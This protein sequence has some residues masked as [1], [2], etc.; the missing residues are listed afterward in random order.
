VKTRALLFIA[1]ALLCA[2]CGGALHGSAQP[3]ASPAATAS[4][5]PPPP[6]PSQER[7]A[8]DEGAAIA[9]IRA[10]MET[11]V[12][13]AY[14][15]GERPAPRDAHAKAHGCVKAHF[16]VLAAVPQALRAG[17]FARPHVYTAW[18]RFSNA[19]G[20][21]DHFGLARGMA[22]KL[23]GVPGK[24]ILAAEAD[25]TTQDFLLVNYPVF[26]V[27]TDGEYVEFFK[28]SRDGKLPAFLATHPESAAITAAIS[29]QRVGDPLRV[30][31]FS[32]TPYALGTRYV[33]Y[34]ARPV[35]C[36]TGKALHDAAT[37]ALPKAADYLRTAMADSL[38]LGASC[39]SFMVQPQTDPAAMP[40][41]DATVLWDERASPF[42][43]VA[44]IVIP[45]QRF[46]SATQQ[47]F[48]ENL[49]Y[50][51]WHALPQHRPAG[52]INRIRR[53]VYDAISALRHD[54]N[55]V[56]RREPTGNERFPGSPTW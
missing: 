48:C 37:G 1:A 46:E 6:P 2:G 45:A 49:S 29:A 19:V 38:A 44:T 4:A 54:L 5:P 52:N 9:E 56:A 12:R 30:R 39:F 53:V 47:A 33:K 7:A 15:K 21:D 51:P 14:A 41:E 40:V 20:S 50:T 36:A 23:T 43:Q 18:L 28:A 27:H 8:P 55:G 42:V 11:Q 34:S 32:M 22:I 24:K 35:D 26:N 13:G 16:K 31:Y 10:M 25:A 3:A 17:V